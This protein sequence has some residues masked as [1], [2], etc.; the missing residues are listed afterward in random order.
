MTL[1]FLQ[2]HQFVV[3]AGGNVGFK[4]TKNWAR[5]IRKVQKSNFLN[6]FQSKTIEI[7]NS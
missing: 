2:L 4:E 6:Q 5:V 1:L 3:L 7:K